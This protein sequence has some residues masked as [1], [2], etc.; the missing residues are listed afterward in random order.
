LK[1]EKPNQIYQ[2]I[3]QIMVLYLHQ[4]TSRHHF[5][6]AAY[7]F[8]YKRRSIYL[9]LF[10]PEGPN[11]PSIPLAAACSYIIY[12]YVYIFLPLSVA[13]IIIMLFKTQV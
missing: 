9:V 1:P 13:H 3:I 11:F 7:R 10:R 2:R 5:L 8:G 6:F 12:L 4:S